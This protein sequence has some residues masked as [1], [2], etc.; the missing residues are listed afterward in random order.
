MIDEIGT[1]VSRVAALIED[2]QCS[3]NSIH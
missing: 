3:N 1:I 2:E